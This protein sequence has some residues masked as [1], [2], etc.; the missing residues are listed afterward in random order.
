MFS[1]VDIEKYRTV[2]SYTAEEED[3][4]SFEPSLTVEVLQKSLTGWWLI[5]CEGKVGLAP[6]TYLKKI[7]EGSEEVGALVYDDLLT[8]FFLL[9]QSHQLLIQG[10]T[11][12]LRSKMAL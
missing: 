8:L 4:I 3:E 10:L 7:E 11:V 2:A 12:A 9:P 1:I 6:A 5:R